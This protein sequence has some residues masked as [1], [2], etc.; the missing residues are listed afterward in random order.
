MIRIKNEKEYN[1][2]LKRV[3]ELAELIDDKTS[4]G[5]EICIE[6]E[7]LGQMLEEYDNVHNV[8]EKP[9]FVDVLKL[10][11]YEQNLTQYAVAKIL[12]VSQSRISEYL[13]GRSE[14][15]ISVARD[16]SKKFDID[17]NIILGV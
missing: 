3:E 11:M 17:A 16:I 7:L 10:R 6:F 4:K 8:I 15:T 12:N 9:S 1:A 13:N 5:S 2:I 14:P